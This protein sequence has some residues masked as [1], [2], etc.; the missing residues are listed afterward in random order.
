MKRILVWGIALTAMVTLLACAQQRYCPESDFRVEPV[1]GGGALR[2]VE[3]LGSNTDVRIPSRIDGLPVTEIGEYVFSGGHFD[4][5]LSGSTLRLF[6]HNRDT[7]AY[8]LA[9]RV[10]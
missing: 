1:D 8:S 5:E 10:R 3:Y 6:F 7:N 2:I 9:M 4:Y